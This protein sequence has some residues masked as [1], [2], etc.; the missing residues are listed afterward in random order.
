MK[1]IQK[2][3]NSDFQDPCPDWS[4]AQGDKFGYVLMTAP[5]A[6]TLETVYISKSFNPY[7]NVTITRTSTFW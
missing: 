4:A 6:Y 7:D 1:I 3:K 5:D 2:E